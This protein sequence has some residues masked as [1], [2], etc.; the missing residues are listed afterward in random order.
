MEIRRSF[1][2]FQ[3]YFFQHQQNGKLNFFFLEH[4]T[5]YSHFCHY[6]QTISQSRKVENKGVKFQIVILK[7]ENEKCAGRFYIITFVVSEDLKSAFT[8]LPIISLYCWSKIFFCA[9]EYSSI[10]R[11][12]WTTLQAKT[13]HHYY[14]SSS[15][16]SL[17]HNECQKSHITWNAVILIS[18]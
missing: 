16:P 5:F 6:L 14:A 8:T 12:K 3:S 15:L 11:Q 9:S 18:N 10:K 1:F 4:D 2:I 17:I 7:F 13:F